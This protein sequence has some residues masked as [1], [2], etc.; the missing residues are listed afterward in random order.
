[1]FHS[2]S[3][4]SNFILLACTPPAA[5]FFSIFPYFINSFIFCG[6][7]IIFYEW[8]FMVLCCLM[9]PMYICSQSSVSLSHSSLLCPLRP[10]G[11]FRSRKTQNKLI[12]LNLCL[13]TIYLFMAYGDDGETIPWILDR[14]GDEHINLRMPQLMN[15]NK[16]T[17]NAKLLR[18]KSSSLSMQF[19]IM[20]WLVTEPKAWL[21]GWTW[22]SMDVRSHSGL[23]LPATEGLL[24]VTVL[25][26]Q[27]INYIFRIFRYTFEHAQ[28]IEFMFRWEKKRKFLII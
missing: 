13:N 22:I 3:F 24:T 18:L 10:P 26:F 2:I 8:S 21:R 20:A 16:L 12:Y 19:Y 9:I 11:T 28:L 27:Q 6:N 4:P 7:K 1:M 15:S 25:P 17:L 5:S 14:R 23:S